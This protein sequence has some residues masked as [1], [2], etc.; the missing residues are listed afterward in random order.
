[1]SGIE[2]RYA[3]KDWSKGIE[4]ETG[5]RELHARDERARGRVQ[6][7]HRKRRRDFTRIHTRETHILTTES[8]TKHNAWDK[9]ECVPTKK[10]AEIIAFL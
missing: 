10:L 2:K 3:R 4:E 9:Q 6:Q 1:M 5:T 8:S 7:K